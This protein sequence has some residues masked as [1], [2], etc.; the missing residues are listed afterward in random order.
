[1]LSHYGSN[2]ILILV[3]IG[4]LFIFN[5]IRRANGFIGTGQLVIFTYLFTAVMSFLC[6]N[7]TMLSMG[8][9]RLS[10]IPAMYLF[11][12]EYIAAKPAIS[13][14]KE[15]VDALEP[16]NMT[17]YNTLIGM[18]IIATL[19]QAPSIFSSM[20]EGFQKI[21]IQDAAGELYME[22]HD[23]IVQHDGV[24]SNVPSVIFNLLEDISF[25]LFMYYLTL[26]KNKWYILFGFC[27]AISISLLNSISK[28][29]RTGTVLNLISIIVAFLLLK[30]WIPAKRIKFLRAIGSVILG[31]LLSLIVV[32]TISRFTNSSSGALD[33]QIYYTGSANLNF[34][35][36]GLDNGG[37]RYG[38]RTANYF[39]KWLG[40][41]NVPMS[42]KERH[43]KYPQLKI[44]DSSFYTF[45]G[46]FTIDYGPIAPIF[47]F[48]L[49]FKGIDKLSKP[50]GGTIKF[51]QLIPLYVSI[52]I[53]T[54][55]SFYLFSY[56]DNKNMS[57]LVIILLYFVFKLTSGKSVVK[58]TK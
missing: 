5:K 49:L 4:W 10:I 35:Q 25:L 31:L 54:H 30:Q 45:V 44:N 38:D 33:S 55:G 40:F 1:M 43:T 46:D 27:C 36:Y 22:T 29:L 48:I 24:I 41:D 57:L 12:M 6:Y 58:T 18:F 9:V 50:K 26:D 53:C 2:V 16:P 8:Q 37:I 52:Q 11:V 51:Y 7:E 17:V 15:K 21:L 34:N 42:Q 19:I 56:S 39:K 47:I 23:S 13:Y 3:I 20:N 32:F 28:G 14:S